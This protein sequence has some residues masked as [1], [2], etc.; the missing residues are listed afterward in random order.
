[1]QN[2]FFATAFLAIVGQV[3]AGG[4][5]VCVSKGPAN[6]VDHQVTKDCCAAVDHNARFDE[7]FNQCVPWT[8][9]GINTGAMVECCESRGCGS[10]A[11]ELGAD[12]TVCR[13]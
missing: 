1:M 6:C 12:H 3:L 5:E 8:A 7:V 2:I 13:D 9:N 4:P 10:D 11:E